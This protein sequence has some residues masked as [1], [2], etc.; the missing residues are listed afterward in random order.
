M[1]INLKTFLTA[2]RLYEYVLIKFNVLLINYFR[3]WNYIRFGR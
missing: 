3:F 2:R 1:E